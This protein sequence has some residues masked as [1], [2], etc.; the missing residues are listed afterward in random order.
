MADGSM[1]QQCSG[2]AGYLIQ[3]ILRIWLTASNPSVARLAA[4]WF[5]RS[6]HESVPAGSFVSPSE[7][8]KR[9]RLV[10]PPYGDNG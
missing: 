3:L 4:V 7:Y 10:P 1:F 6:Y 5:S 8:R 2:S 9:L